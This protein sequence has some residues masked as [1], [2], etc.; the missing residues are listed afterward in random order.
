[1]ARKKPRSGGEFVMVDVLYDDGS[2]SSNRKIPAADLDGFDDDAIIRTAIEVQDRKI[3]DHSGR[4]PREI[5][6]IIRSAG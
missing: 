3:A 6:S 2:R 1:M 4:A 5:K